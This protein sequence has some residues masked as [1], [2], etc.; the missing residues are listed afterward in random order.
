MK[1]WEAC[2]QLYNEVEKVSTILPII[3]ELSKESIMPR[4]W[5]EV[6]QVTGSQLEIGDPNFKLQNLLDIDIVDYKDE[7]LEITEGADKQLKIQ[8]GLQEITSKWGK[9]QFVFSE[10]KSRGIF[11]LTSTGVVME[12]L[13]E[14]Q[15]NL[16]TMISMR[17]AA[18]FRE[19]AQNTLQS[20]SDTSDVFERWLNVQIM[21]CSLES[22][23]TG[24][25]IAK[26]M[27]TEAKKISRV[28]KDWAKLMQ[29]ANAT[30]IVMECCAN[31]ALRSSLPTM[32]T[33]LEKCQKS[34]EGYLEQKRSKFPRF[35]FVSNPGLLMILSQGSDLLT[36]NEHYEKVFDSIA[37]VSHN[38][39][40]KHLIEA[41][42]GQG[43]GA[44]S[45]PFSQPVK[46]RGNIEDWLCD[47]LQSMQLSMKNLTRS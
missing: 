20:L 1:D 41:F 14:A 25:D 27:P 6:M 8:Q 32:Y 7:L 2:K 21:W 47:L 11:V 38:S 15:L 16:Q 31:Q 40:D 36:M 33:E 35:Y 3:Q 9:E 45:I 46:A 26:Q 34:L 29:K 43:E 39:E 10:W 17:H 18:P 12:E 5:D 19:E 44:E 28:D 23:F 22:V 42:N 37:T 4:H 13:E 30:S 24:G